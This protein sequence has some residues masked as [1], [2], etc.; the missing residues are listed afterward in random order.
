MKKCK[1]T[2]SD[3]LSISIAIASASYGLFPNGN[4][5]LLFTP[6]GVRLCLSRSFPLSSA[7]LLLFDLSQASPPPQK[8]C[9]LPL[10]LFL[11]PLYPTIC[12]RTFAPRA[13]PSYL[14]TFVSPQTTTTCGRRATFCV[15]VCVF[16]NIATTTFFLLVQIPC[17]NSPKFSARPSRPPPP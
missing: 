10:S 11:S 15:C 17:L 4:S 14:H 16:G 3:T 12:H 5:F 6:L 7:S 13:A 9:P 2:I 8:V 1:V